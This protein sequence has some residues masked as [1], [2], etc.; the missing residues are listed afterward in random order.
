MTQVRTPAG[1]G[2]GTGT[3][4]EQTGNSSTTLKL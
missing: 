2:A 1:S 4:S 3:G